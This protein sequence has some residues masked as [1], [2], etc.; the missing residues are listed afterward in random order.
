MNDRA[1]KKNGGDNADELP[2]VVIPKVCDSFGKRLF[3]YLFSLSFHFFIDAVI[4]TH[5]D[6][7]PFQKIFPDRQTVY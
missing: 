7:G 2:F 1:D 3:F 5:D 4:L 6:Y